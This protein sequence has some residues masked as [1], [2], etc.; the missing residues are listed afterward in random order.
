VP[1]AVND[2]P[3]SI[4]EVLESLATIGSAHGLDGSDAGL[5]T[6]NHAYLSMAEAGVVDTARLEVSQG[7]IATSHAT[8]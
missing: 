7:H 6:L 1:V 5:R 3:M 8:T 4:V 2:V